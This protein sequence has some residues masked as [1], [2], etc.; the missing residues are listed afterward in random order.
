MLILL[1]IECKSPE[2][3]LSSDTFYSLTKFDSKCLVWT[4]TK[5]QSVI[6]LGVTVEQ[7]KNQLGSFFGQYKRMK[8]MNHKII[9]CGTSEFLL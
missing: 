1:K 9:Y 6:K 8:N 7:I 5:V 4:K 2:V 3:V